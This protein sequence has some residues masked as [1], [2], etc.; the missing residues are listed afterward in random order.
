MSTKTYQSLEGELTVRPAPSVPRS[1]DSNAVA[2]IGGYDADNASN[3]VTAGES[4]KISEPV[5]ATDTFGDCEITRVASVMAANG[6]SNIFAIPVP[7]T[8]ETESFTASQSLS[9]SNTPVFDPSVHPDHEITVTDTNS[10]TDLIV[11]LVY[12]TTVTTPTESETANVNPITGDIETDA[13]SDYDVS[14]TYGDYTTAI[15]TAADL[16]VR[17]LCVLTEAPSVKATAASTVSNVAADFDF[18]RVTVG[19]RPEID[20]AEVTNYT[21]DEASWRMVEVAPAR[22]TAESGGV[23]TQAAVTGRMASQPIGP[24]GSALFESLNGLTDLNTNYRSTTAQKFDSVTVVDRTQTIG[25][26]VTTS[27]SEQFRNVYA[28][29]IVDEIALRLFGVAREYAGGPQDI[30]DLRTLLRGVCQNAANQS[31]PLLGFAQDTGANPYDINVQLGSSD[32]VAEGAVTIVPTPI[33]EEVNL[34]LTVSD[35]F[36]TFEG[37]Q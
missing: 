23:R 28:T 18:K 2:I 24:D 11:N 16:P 6:T 10:S 7:E 1:N 12:S 13:S 15:N 14:Y 37:T 27:E 5:D 22:G 19:A 36:V 35:N 29:E 34:S 32:G 9:L 33:A 25:Q 26:A 21:P 17:Y 4:I 3:E 30:G 31:P 20:E 8:T